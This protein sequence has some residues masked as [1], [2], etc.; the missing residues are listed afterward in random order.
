MQ[1]SDDNNQD[2][3]LRPF[4]EAL[5]DDANDQFETLWYGCL[6]SKVLMV[7]RG[8]KATKDLLEE[9]ISEASCRLV[10]ALYKRRRGE[11]SPIEDVEKYTKEVARNVF[12]DRLRDKD[13]LRRRLKL[14]VLSLPKTAERFVLW[15]KENVTY[16]GL[17]LW[18][19]QWFQTPRYQAFK[20]EDYDAFLEHQLE[21]IPPDEVTGPQWTGLPKLAAHI[22]AWLQTPIQVDEMVDFLA[23]LLQIGSSNPVSVEPDQASLVSDPCPEQRVLTREM[24]RQLGRFICKGRLDRYQCASILLRR[25][26]E[27]LCLGRVGDEG[28]GLGLDVTEIADA[29][30]YPHEDEARF[31][32]FLS[33]IWRKLPF[34]SDKEI[35]TFLGFT[36][37]DDKIREEIAHAQP[38]VGDPEDELRKRRDKKLA[39][40]ISFRRSRVLNLFKRWWRREDKSGKNEQSYEG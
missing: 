28:A 22:F 14:K 13:P 35:A 30:G 4:L 31:Q 27:E 8:K 18:P 36:I 17:L 11:G 3:R 10:E 26:L 20:E 39:D 21:N 1:L 38:P 29:L 15:K 7:L 2:P 9:L 33:T 23:D 34:T 12:N 5:G 6:E 40:Q 37:P 16:C 19:Q 25:S 24:L 32:E